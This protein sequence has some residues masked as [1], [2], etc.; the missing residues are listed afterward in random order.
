MVKK[1]GDGGVI[2]KIAELVHEKKLTEISDLAATSRTA[3]ACGS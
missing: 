3:T 2:R 1:G